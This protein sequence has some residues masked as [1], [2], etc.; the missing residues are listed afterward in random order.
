MQ[1]QESDNIEVCSNKFQFFSSFWVKYGSTHKC[2]LYSKHSLVFVKQIFFIV[3]E[4][5]IVLLVFSH[6]LSHLM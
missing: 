3:E 6:K 4:W 1:T 2:C 5:V